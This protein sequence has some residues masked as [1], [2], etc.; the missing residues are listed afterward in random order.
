MKL[1]NLTEEYDEE[2]GDLPS[3]TEVKKLLPNIVAAV[4]EEYDSWDENQDEYAGGGIC[5]LIA[6]RICGVLGEHNIDCFTVSA[7][8]GDQH[9]WTIAKVREGVYNVDIN[10]HMYEMGGGYTWTKIPDVEFQV[11]D[12]EF[13]CVDHDPS[14]FD[15]YIEQ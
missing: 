4:Q 8:I 13:D 6:D 3:I 7:E 9:V 12:I 2:D 11:E 1:F 14:K 15:R 5:H 10:P